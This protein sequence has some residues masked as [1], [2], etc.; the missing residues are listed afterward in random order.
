MSHK[1]ITVIA[2]SVCVKYLGKTK[3]NKEGIQYPSLSSAVRHVPHGPDI[4]VPTLRLPQTEISS[5]S[6]AEDDDDVH[7][8]SDTESKNRQAFN[9]LELNDLVRDLGLTKE[10]SKLFGSRLKQEIF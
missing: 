8:S 1:I 6:D 7:F 3:K 5:P 10:K 9:Q 2:I 4:P